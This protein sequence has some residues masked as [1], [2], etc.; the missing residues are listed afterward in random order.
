MTMQLL[1]TEPSGIATKNIWCCGCGA[2]VDARL[3]DGRE[4]Y[5]HRPDLRSLPFW[6]CDAC[7]NFVGCHH[8]TKNR[9]RPLGCIPTTELKEARKHLHALIDPIWQS[10]KMS[11]RDL[12]A[13]ISRD[14][15]WKYHT[16][17]IRTIVE[18][19]KV[20]RVARKYV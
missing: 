9:T 16:A 19:R 13:A 6:R 15:G 5:P 17:E 4:I 8:K 11:R 14:L 7:G 1:L 2:Y 10:G 3:T 18:A 20:Y 12:Y